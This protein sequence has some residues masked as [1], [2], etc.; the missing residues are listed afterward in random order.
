[1]PAGLHTASLRLRDRVAQLTAAHAGGLRGKAVLASFW[2]HTC[3]NWFRQSAAVF[4]VG[5][6]VQAAA[7][8]A[9]PEEDRALPVGARPCSPEAD[10]PLPLIRMLRRPQPVPVC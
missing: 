7:Q 10:P 5:W 9:G 6:T 3:I 4:A 1:M 8:L 2:T